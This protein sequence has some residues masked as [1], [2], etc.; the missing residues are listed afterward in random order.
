M[1]LIEAG[2]P[3]TIENI[4][5][6]G[7]LQRAV[8]HAGRLGLLDRAPSRTPTA[9]A[10]TCR[11]ARPSGAPPR[12]TRWSTSAAT[13]PT[14]TAGATAGCEGWGFDDLL[15]YFIRAEDNER[16]ASELHGAGGPLTVSE[17]RAPNPITDAFL[18]ACA[19]AGLPANEDF[20]GAAQDGFGRYQRTQRDGRRCSAAVAYLHPAMARPNLTVETY[21]QVHRVLF[22][23]ERAVGVQ[24]ARLGELHE[25]RATRE[26]ILCGGA[27]N[28]PQLLMLSGVGPAELLD[29]AADPRRPG[30]AQRR[31]EPP[32]PPRL[33]GSRGRTTS[34]S[35]CSTR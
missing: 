1:A 6:P 5:V 24:A 3:D 25:L 10:S 4:H 14:T 8:P 13:A 35:R 7:R 22:E 34:R 33:A 16:G 19:Q 28:S 26:T 31:A 23:G 2:P 20:N 32:G 15:P 30:S 18:E 29:A 11:A 17:D 21:M 9:G 12:P 27:Y